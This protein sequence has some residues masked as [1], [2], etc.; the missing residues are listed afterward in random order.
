MRF[1]LLL[2]EPELLEEMANSSSEAGNLPD[3]PLYQEAANP[4]NFRVVSKGL[5]Q[6]KTHRQAA[7]WWLLRE[8]VEGGKKGQIKE[9]K[10]MVTER[11]LAL[12]GKHRMQYQIVYLQRCTRETC[13]ILLTRASQ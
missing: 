10:C 12:G 3:E 2:Q 8:R 7:V 5:R 11:D 9:V 6:T 1:Y 4:G 13:I